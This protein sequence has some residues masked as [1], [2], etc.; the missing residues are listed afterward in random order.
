MQW[1]SIANIV[2]LPFSE[3]LSASTY[4]L[5]VFDT[6]L[7]KR[8]EAILNYLIKYFSFFNYTGQDTLLV[9]EWH[10]QIKVKL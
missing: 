5:N 4:K 2:T 1:I 7:V 9:N 10:T 3:L 8:H 6:E